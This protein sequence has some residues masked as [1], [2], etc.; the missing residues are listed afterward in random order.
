MRSWQ[1]TGLQPRRN[2]CRFFPSPKFRKTRNSKDSPP[3]YCVSVPP[4]RFIGIALFFLFATNLLIAQNPRP[5]RRDFVGD[6][7][8]KQ[9]HAATSETY[10][11]T[12]HHLTSQ[13][14]SKDSIAGSFAPGANLLETSN[15]DLHFRMDARENG[16]YETGVFW[17]HPDEKFRSERIDFV[18]GSGAKGQTYLHWRGNQLFQLPLSYWTELHDWVNSPGFSDGVADFDRPIVPR[19][20]E[21]HATYFAPSR[22]RRPRTITSRSAT[23]WAFPVSAATALAANTQR[24]SART[25]RNL[26]VEALPSLI[27]TL[28]RVTG[29]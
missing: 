27:R 16:F 14:A 7:A 19:C 21:C 28:S 18:T 8:C 10:L 2:C 12:N 23:F 24:S 15:P 29:G 17:Q 25:P 5:S 22:R 9:R 4:A 3:R 13:L 6:A 11:H 26:P 20:L 1:S